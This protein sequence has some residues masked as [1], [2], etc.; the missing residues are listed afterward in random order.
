MKTQVRLAS[1]SLFTIL[2]L[3]LAVAPA[4]A[5]T[6]Y[7]NGPLNGDANPWTINY[8]YSVSD[9]FTVASGSLITDF[10]FT[11]WDASNTDILSQVDLNIS[12]T[13]FGNGGPGTVAG[14]SLTNTPLLSG[15]PNEY[16]YYMFQA[17]LSFAG[18]PWSGIGFVTLGNACTTLSG[19]APSPEPL[20]WDENS[21]AGCGG[22]QPGGGNC[23]STAYES[24]LGTIPSEAFTLT[25]Q[26]GGTTPEPS[27][28]M[29]FGS[30]II[31][32]AGVL[33]RR[34]VG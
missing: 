8:G 31:G 30:G 18:I 24:G 20:Y 6:L 27:S 1:L 32:L 33:R 9:S 22:T 21:G 11:Y 7:D 29:L 3:T 2:Y 17:N 23:P 13:S 26:G 10:H 5:G 28:I 12:S 14:L 19:C 16:G 4:M 25:G 15:E 34:L